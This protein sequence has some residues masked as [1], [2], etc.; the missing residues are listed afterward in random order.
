MKGFPVGKIANVVGEG[1]ELNGTLP[2]DWKVDATI[3]PTEKSFSVDGKVSAQEIAKFVNL[4]LPNELIDLS[5]TNPNLSFKEEDENES[6]DFS[7]TGTLTLDK[8]YFGNFTEIADL[9]P[10]LLYTSPSPRDA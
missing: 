10:C 5:L 2:E 7:G 6:F 8:K 4:N 3:T 9:F 1:V